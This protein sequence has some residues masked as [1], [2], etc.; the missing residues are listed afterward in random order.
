[1][2]AKEYME[3]G[4]LFRRQK[5]LYFIFAMMAVIGMKIYYS[6]GLVSDPNSRLVG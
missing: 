3:N 4:F 1:M 2:K 5:D 6:Y